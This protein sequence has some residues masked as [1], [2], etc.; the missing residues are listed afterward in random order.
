MTLTIS[1]NFKTFYIPESRKTSVGILPL[2]IEYLDKEATL[3]K[4]LRDIKQLNVRELLKVGGGG[5][6]FR[7][8]PTHEPEAISK[9]IEALDLG[10]PFEQLGAAGKRSTLA[11]GLQTANEGP[12]SLRMWLVLFITLY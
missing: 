8:L 4:A 5:V 3:E 11:N 12:P 2:G 1:E 9:A 10:Q 7:G 6:L